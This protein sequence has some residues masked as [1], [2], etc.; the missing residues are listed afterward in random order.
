MTERT[1]TP[2]NPRYN[3]SWGATAEE[4][5]AK[6][7]IWKDGMYRMPEPKKNEAGE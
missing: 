2:N 4:M 1:E 5:I 6:G 3:I 7:Y